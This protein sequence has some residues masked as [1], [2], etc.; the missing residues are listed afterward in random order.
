MQLAFDP[1][2]T[3]CLLYYSVLYLI[4]V[5]THK[6]ISFLIFS[7]ILDAP[8]TDNEFSSQLVILNHKINFVKEQSF[9]GK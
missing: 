9:K 1:P 6:L 3:I 7:A 8:V 4:I 5:P 2:P